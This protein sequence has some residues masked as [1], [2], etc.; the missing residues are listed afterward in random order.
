MSDENEDKV[1]KPYVSR[2]KRKH[3]TYVN[4]I[5]VLNDEKAIEGILNPTNRPLEI[6]PDKDTLDDIEM[7]CKLHST[8]QEIYNILGVTEN[9]W[10]TFKNKYPEVQ[11]AMERGKSAG[12][13]S[14]RHKQFQMAIEQNS[15][16]MAIWLGKQYLG[17][18]DKTQTENN[19]NLQVLKTIMDLEEDT[20]ITISNNNSN[21]NS[22][23]E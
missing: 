8:E 2:V 1:K 21:G 14:L 11:H 13:L 6:T 22:N 18:T 7:M 12:R 23:D 19:V 4:K 5:Y 15:V 17:Q 9:T 3:T 10:I 16:Q 20:P